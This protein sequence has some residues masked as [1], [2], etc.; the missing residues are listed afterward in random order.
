M[1]FLGNSIDMIRVVFLLGAV[2]ALICKKV[3]GVTPGGI[4]APGI[5]A[6][7]MSFSF[8]SFLIT[9]G[10]ALL[11]WGIYKLFLAGFA[12]STRW[13]SLILIAISTVIG[14]T[15]SVLIHLFTPIPQEALLFSLVVPGLIAISA[16]KYTM[17]RVML[18]LLSVTALTVLGGLL[19]AN[20]IPYQQLSFLSV[21][22]GEYVPLTLANPFVSL[23]LALAT[24]MVLY[25]KFGVRSGGYLIAPFLASVLFFS[26][27]QF[28]FLALGITASYLL[29]KLIQKFT[30]I[31][32]LERFVVCLFLAY[33]VVSMIDFAAVTYGIPNYH[34]APIVLIT[35]VS[36]VTNDLCLQ[37]AG[38]M[39]KKGAG[40]AILT[41]YLARLAV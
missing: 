35:A 22:L 18:A 11:C 29:M 10:S 34:P 1:D 14:L 4:I 28:V 31:I 12:L 38:S 20:V 39:L 37:G 16:R 21:S 6:Y 36:V 5:L 13:R 26:P 23:P 2:L 27:I 15:G 24:A 9:I 3:Y 33:F 40:P 7:S 30:L 41:S 8:T 32:G 19:L 25:W 17:P